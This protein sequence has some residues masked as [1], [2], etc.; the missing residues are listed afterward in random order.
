MN[1]M[2]R[3]K[4]EEV[5]K[6]L[7]KFNYKLDA[8]ANKKEI[9]IFTDEVKK[10]F[11]FDLPEEYIDLLKVI[12]G[13]EFNGFIIYG[14]DERL[15]EKKPDEHINGF[16]ELSEIWY[17]NEHQK[18]YI[19]IGEDNISWYVYDFVSKKYVIVD[20]PGGDEMEYFDRF[21]EIIAKLLTDSIL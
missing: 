6:V 5:E 19:F 17:E 10:K 11:G 15:L 13:Y 14:V 9:Q 1:S 12:N 16:I 8:P 2:W 4:L 7:S 18:Q 21:D 20:K 3:E